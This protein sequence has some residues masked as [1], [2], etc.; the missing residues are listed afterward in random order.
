MNDELKKKL[1]TRK[2]SSIEYMEEMENYFKLGFAGFKESIQWFYD[3]PPEEVDW[4][5]WHISKRPDGWDDRAT[6]N[7]EIIE[8]SVTQGILDYKNGDVNRIV[9]TSN[10][11]MT[12]SR[13]M[14]V[15]DDL[16]WE[17]VDKDVVKKYGSN[18]NEARK[19][20]SNIYRTLGGGFE[21]RPG[22]ITD[23]EITGVIDKQDLLR[24]LKPEE[25]V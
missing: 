23:E 7:L 3:H 6:P 5:N 19:R 2:F 15:L 9:G 17:Y 11:I 21:S 24:Y 25:K 16:W 8:E 20:A 13:D 4:Q 1:L 10:N 14:D 12:L 18:M 22:S